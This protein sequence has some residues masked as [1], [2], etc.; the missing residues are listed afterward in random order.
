M[1][2]LL[3]HAG[4]V[5]GF[6]EVKMDV[7]QPDRIGGGERATS[8]SI[9]VVQEG[10]EAGVQATVFALRWRGA[11]DPGISEVAPHLVLHTEAPEAEVRHPTDLGHA[12]PDGFE[13]AG[14]VVCRLRNGP[15][16][17][18]DLVPPPQILGGAM[19]GADVVDG[20]DEALEGAVVPVEREAV[21]VEVTH[22]RGSGDPMDELE[23]PLLLEGRC[24]LRPD[25]VPVLRHDRVDPPVDLGI[26]PADLGPYVV[27]RQ[28]GRSFPVDAPDEARARLHQGAEMTFRPGPLLF[29]RPLSDLG[30]DPG[31]HEV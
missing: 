13:E 30:R 27:R 4:V 6:V 12:H 9:V 22:S 20:A 24:P 31:S 1:A 16:D 10:G 25:P 15:Q 21:D 14:P 29:A 18:Q 7:L 3:E 5:L 2:R 11:P 8:Q 23:L 19:H 17:P 26:L 28:R